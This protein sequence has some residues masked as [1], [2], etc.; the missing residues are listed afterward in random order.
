MGNIGYGQK[1]EEVLDKVQE[2]VLA[3]NI[4]TPWKNGQ[5]SR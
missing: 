1:Q 4:M 5:P 2:L 3:L